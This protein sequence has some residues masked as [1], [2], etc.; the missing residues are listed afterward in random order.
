MAKQSFHRICLIF[1]IFET[2]HCSPAITTTPSYSCWRQ[3]QI[4]YY[5]NTEAHPQSQQYINF[6]FERFSAFTPFLFRY[7]GRNAAGIRHD[8]KNTI[9][10]LREW[11]TTI[12]LSHIGFTQ[13]WYDS[14]GIVEADI[15]LNQQS[16]GFTTVDARQ[17]GKYFIEG[18]L[19]HEIGHLIGLEHSENKD[20]FM[21]HYQKPEETEWNLAFSDAMLKRLKPCR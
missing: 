16:V 15:I 1:V 10:F 8:S 11:P 17:P 19:A 21:H 5:I 20:S 18:V 13:R 4:D 7:L 6:I 9:S 14:R 3:T 2:L 12:P